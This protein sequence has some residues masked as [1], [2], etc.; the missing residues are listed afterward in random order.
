MMNLGTLR[1]RAASRTRARVARAHR[2]PSVTFWAVIMM[3][4]FRTDRDRAPRLPGLPSWK[5]RRA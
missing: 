2:D 4:N 1:N 5:F 3:M